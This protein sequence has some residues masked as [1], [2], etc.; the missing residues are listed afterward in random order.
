[1]TQ[2]MKKQEEENAPGATTTLNPT[3]YDLSL[4]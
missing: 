4:T 2:K 1:M 3:V